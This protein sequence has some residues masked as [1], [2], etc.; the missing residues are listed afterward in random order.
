MNVK[1][2]I[3]R[4]TFLTSLAA[5]FGGALCA[6]NA[7]GGNF[8]AAAEPFEM[9]VVGDSLVW[10]QGLTE[11]QKFY[12]LT[13]HWLRDE[14]FKGDRPVNLN[15]R[16]H[17]GS[18]IKLD[19]TEAAAFEKAERDISKGVHPEI[20]VSFPTIKLQVEAARK[21]YTDPRSVNLI[22]LS[23][24]VPDVGISNILNP[25]QNDERLRT[26]IKL[27]CYEHMSEL[28]RQTADAFPEALIAVVGYYP[29]ITSHTPVKRIVN[30][31]LE[32]YN[33]PG[34]TKTLLNNPL[35]RVLWRRFRRRMIRRSRIWFEDSTTYLTQAVGE[36]N[37]ATKQRAIFV[38]TSFAAENGYGARNTYL[39]TVA[40]DG[41]AADPRALD[42]EV[43]CGPVLQELRRST[44]LNYRKRV[45][46]LASIGH[47][48]AKG[49]AAIAAAVR[50]NLQ[51]HLTA[52]A[53][54]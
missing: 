15:V 21:D 38:P 4:R 49:A 54:V 41:G 23:G 8:F 31:I 51:L 14:V 19:Q 16:A 46:E 45:C 52:R 36:I 30:D 47:P 32:L 43:N 39:W 35:Q 6:R 44:D 26:D 2:A 34:W 1:T 5:S 9:L 22:L 7:L 48:N 33:W 11:D 50:E 28:L 13:K 18:T 40:D 27:Y 24:G 12:R 3:S 17:S 20:N 42:R 10:G 25:F 29:I 37:T 53:R